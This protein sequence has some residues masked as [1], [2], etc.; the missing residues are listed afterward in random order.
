MGAQ[1]PGAPGIVGGAEQ[2]RQ[3]LAQ[4]DSDQRSAL[5]EEQRGEASEPVMQRIS[6]EID[7]TAALTDFFAGLVD[8]LDAG[9]QPDSWSGRRRWASRLIGKYLGGEGLRDRWPEAERDAADRVESA[10]DRLGGLDTVEAAPSLTTFRRALELELESGL[11]RTGRLGDGVL[12]GPIGLALGV[13]LDHVVVVGMAE[14]SFP[15]I[16]RED[17]LLPDSERAVAGSELPL[18]T[19]RVDEQHRHFIAAT[20]AANDG[21]TL[22]YPRGDLRRSTQRVGSRW[23]PADVEINHSP[24]FVGGLR[25]LLLPA[26]EQEFDLRSL[27]DHAELGEPIEDHLL[28]R[29]NNDLGQGVVALHARRTGRFTRFDGNLAGLDAADPT[30]DIV[31]A[32]PARGLHEVPVRVLHAVRAAR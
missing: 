29:T 16:V 17:S 31:S 32:H 1:S 19:S 25:T 6:R 27:L 18:R 28:V 5:E 13:D 26:T 8:D 14:G 11:G 7:R 9:G 30:N 22:L 23:L 4:F 3:R 21:V 20:T 2:W 24:S 10:L 15:S 12:V